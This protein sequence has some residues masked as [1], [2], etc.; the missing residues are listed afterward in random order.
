[1]TGAVEAIAVNPGNAKN[2][3]VGGVN[4][5]VWE[6][7]DITADPVAWMPLTDTFPALEISALQFD[8]TDASNQTIVAGIGNTS[9]IGTNLGPL[10]GLLKTT[11]GGSTWTQLG[12]TPVMGL[13]NEGVS[14]VLPRSNTIL[15]GVVKGTAPGLYSSPDNGKTFQLIS[16]LNN[17]NNGPVYDVAA[18]PSNPNRAYV[19][20]GG[21]SGGVFRTDNLGAGWTNITDA[22]ATPAIAAQLTS[23]TL[24]NAKLSVSAAMPNPVY[25]AIADNN[26]LSGVF[27]SADMGGTWST[28]DL[29]QTLDSPRTITAASNASP[30]VITVSA[31]E[32]YVTG[33]TVQ[34]TGVT[35]NTAAN[36][37]FTITKID[38]TDFSLNGTTGNGAYVSGGTVSVVQGINRGS[39]AFPNLT[40]ATDP[41]NANLVYIA[42]D[43]EQF[44][45]RSQP[46]RSP[47]DSSLGASNF[48]ARIFRGDASIAPG[49]A[50]VVPSPQ[51]SPL[52]NSG[53]SNNSAP[54]ADSRAMEIDN[55]QLLYSGDGG[56]FEET[57]PHDATGKWVSVNGA[58]NGASS[59]LQ[60][61]QFSSVISY[62]SISNIIFGGAQDTGTPQESASGSQVYQDQTQSDGP[63]T[64]VDDL[65]ST[66][67]SA[68]YIGF[69]R[70]DYDSANNPIGSS[71]GLIPMAGVSGFSN[72]GVLAVS[73][74][75]PP[76]G[77][78]TLVVIANGT[79]SMMPGVS[80]IFDSTDAGMAT[81]TAGIHYTQI[82]TGPGWNGVN[83]SPFA[84]N[85]GIYAIA[86]G[87]T[88][89]GVVNQNVIYAA[90]GS[91][92]FLRSTAGG[93]LTATAGQP[94]G[95]G[96]IQD[97]A[98]DPDNWMTAYVTDG[99][100]V[101][102]TNDAG[103]T[104]T[105]ITG[106]LKDNNIHTVTVADSSSGVSAVLVGETDGVF[107]M[108]SSDPQVWT[109]FGASF[110][111]SSVW[112][113]QY[114]A[115]KDLLV[116][117]TSGRGAFEIQNASTSLFS[118]AVLT[119]NGDQDF[120]NE[121]DT[122]KLVLDPS[123]PD[124]LDV[125]RNS[126]TPIATYE[127]S[128]IAQINVNGL[129]GNDTLIV[130]SSNGLITVPN[131]IRYDG[132]IGDN[133]LQLLQT[134]GTPQTSDTYTVITNP[135]Q[136]SD[137]I[138]GP[139]GTQTVDF[140]NLAPVYDNVPAPLTVVGTPSNNTINYEAGPNSGNAAAPYNGDTTGLVT[141]DNFEPLKFSH[142]SS[143]TLQGQNGD[144][145]FVINN[146][147]T[148]T[149]L[150]TLNVDGMAGNNT[151]VVDANSMPVLSS[152]VT[153]TSVN[154]PG[155]TP[156]AVGY[157]NI[158][159]VQIIHATDALT[160]T[161]A[162]VP[163][164]EGVPLNNVLVASFNFTDPV[165]PPVLGNP[166]DFTATINWG[167]GTATTSGT[168]VENGTGGFQ[169]FGTHTYT[170]ENTKP[171]PIT[172]TIND[173]GSTRS[174]TP[175]GFGAVPVTIVD[176]PGATTTTPAAGMAGAA[177]AIVMDAPLTGQVGAID[178]TEGQP[179]PVT[180]ILA[181]FNDTDPFGVPED[182]TATIDWGDGTPVQPAMI[183]EPA[184]PGL[185]FNVSQ[186]AIQGHTYTEDGDYTYTVTII[187]AGGSKL[188]LVGN[189]LVSDAKL[190]AT[191]L[192]TPPVL[193]EGT[194]YFDGVAATFSDAD[195]GGNV[196][197][198]VATINW[199]DGTITNG[200]VVPGTPGLFNVT[201]THTF[202]EGTYP[203]SVTINDTGDRNGVTGSTVT[204]VTT[205]IITDAPLLVAPIAPTSAVEGQSFSAAVGAFTDANPEA[206]V[207]D[208][209]A[210][211]NWG[212]GTP[213]TTGTVSQQAGGTF[214]VSGS[215][216]YA[217]ESPAG[218]PYAI[219]FTV[220]DV[221]GSTLAAAA[222]SAVAVADA[223]LNG[224]GLALAGTEGAAL[225]A[226]TV[227]A[228]FT[229][230][231][232]A[233]TAAD[234]TAKINWGDGT[235]PAA[236]VIQ[237]AFGAGSTFNVIAMH[238]YAEEGTYV[239]NVAINDAGASTAT[240]GSTAIIADAPM[241]AVGKNNVATEGTPFSGVVASFLDADPAGVATDYTATI[242]WADGTSSLGTISAGLF[243]SFDVSGTHTYDEGT[244]P[245]SVT[246][247]D[248][249]GAV[250]TVTSTFSIADAPLT[251]AAASSPL[252]ATEAVPFS[253]TVGAFTDANPLST[254]TDFTA[255][256]DW[257]DGTS[258]PGTIKKLADSSYIVI[259]THLYAEETAAGAPLPVSVTV[260]DVGGQTA[261]LD[262]TATVA[263]APLTSSGAALAGTEGQPL[264]AG[265]AAA[266]VL[267]ATFSDADP[268][269]VVADYT[270]SIDWGDGTVSPATRITAG[271]TP[272]GVVFSVYGSHTYAEEGSYAVN[273]TINDA[274]G[275]QTV[276]HSSAHVADAALLP[277]APPVV[278]TREG[279]ALSAGTPVAAFTDNNPGAPVSDFTATIDWGDGSPQSAGTLSQPGGPG[280]PF[281]VSGGHTYADSGVNGGVGTYAIKVHVTDVGGASVD[282]ANKAAVADAPLGLGGQLNP[283][284]DSGK[285]NNDGITSVSQ[286]NFFG[287]VE[288]FATVT[289]YA[290]P[291]G[292]GSAAP[293]GQG[294]ADSSGYW[295]ITSNHL[296]D[297]SYTITASAVD[298]YGK[299]TTP[300][301]VAIQTAANS[302][303]LVI[304]TIGPRVTGVSFDR[305][306]GT[307]RVSFGDDLAGLLASTLGDANNYQLTR[308]HTRP[309]HFLVTGLSTTP[310][311]GSG[312]QDVTV[313][314]NGGRSI[315]G[316]RFTFTIRSAAPGNVSGV[317]DLAG[318]P[319]DGEFY[320][321]FPSGNG[322]PGGDFVAQ[323]EA[324]HNVVKPPATLVGFPHPNDP[325]NPFSR[326]GGHHRGARSVVPR[327]A[328]GHRPTPTS[329]PGTNVSPTSTLLYGTS[330]GNHGP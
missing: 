28:M 297:G 70:Q 328:H 201:G 98:M 154:I 117:G 276:A 314:L 306:T 112:G 299:T 123:N 142:K 298:Q 86:V 252:T 107:R 248:N 141:V 108:L 125:Y 30:I 68:R 8:P 264:G 82:P 324:F 293:I 1:V 251:P 162:T 52:V 250:A 29:P 294:E 83:Q 12:N 261:T 36:G 130:D 31:G 100:Q 66:T 170:E 168:I 302:G 257:G 144:D 189:T 67:Q 3:F 272:S 303:P 288:P 325:P 296:A 173:K 243:G 167:D 183:T 46:N 309:G 47:M 205:F 147:T 27:R 150:T 113:V 94:A 87:G 236:A 57:S 207:E 37:T 96:K 275:S 163:A 232:P 215:H 245:A 6:T 230:A 14:A 89:N 174:F 278:A 71:V 308:P 103:A 321:T 139:S 253:A 237:P 116:A 93:T 287:T 95:A 169:V 22:V 16:G 304:D 247:R 91:Q 41:S 56:I 133:T 44:P 124:V 180:T 310:G 120:A 79:N 199:G 197:D 161:G 172:V 15:V 283:A 43:A 255:T 88:S 270:G 315:K 263:D 242:N 102:Q 193:R 262:N 258:S 254:T 220:Q 114:N 176:I 75:A 20:V 280:T 307:I 271:G 76:T 267:V 11:D 81:S 77:Q 233:G 185:P 330:G 285:F 234:Y 165:P 202:D 65:T 122:F 84:F 34:I 273:V 155:A 291:S 327:P 149:G 317:S 143:L 259:G 159:Q 249:G 268:V 239:V 301:P 231:D 198:Y 99:S 323:L 319:L 24:S 40:L 316:G 200:T 225:P 136:G 10:T 295:T 105:N 63:F 182:Y 48:T 179:I 312:P 39:Q 206:T 78:S 23:A 290:T 145:T 101:F 148:P 166:E 260:L 311:G 4:G 256:I 221:G 300:A 61:T 138:M 158:Q 318:N 187:D 289:L 194:P 13:Q 62:D 164:V 49:G 51:W 121:D 209:S 32:T 305:L 203:V 238:T 33:D 157:T 18:D 274:G 188:V 171:Y 313:L 25:L 126:T 58:P 246:I 160:S 153:N 85:G 135:G 181:T 279:V 9:N 156:V 227:V 222:G 54:H 152:D 286:P 2:V 128:T 55:G 192:P 140:Q 326:H 131:G 132:G 244:Y 329:T 59:G 38:N 50:N 5:G 175:T 19:V 60:V 213:A 151:L 177:Q 17:L 235:A 190:S 210:T 74:V 282:L 322:R 211:I 292:G 64:A 281:V 178:A 115:A 26:Q 216:T 195:P 69:S 212:D 229:D 106:N 320:G 21:A 111:N 218:T 265:S 90:S 73:N 219:T 45:N 119:I 129:G 204:A 146:T 127:L 284:S 118:Q 226:G 97:V 208:F 241:T 191:G 214:I 224:N 80:A 186:A 240:A 228:T 277:V 134:G 72:F 217:E 35:G 137:V 110:P 223:P 196:S 184:G 266:D 42:G 53:T 7:T 269:G 109:K 104:W 92:V